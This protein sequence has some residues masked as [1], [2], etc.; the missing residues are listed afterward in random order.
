MRAGSATAGSYPKLQEAFENEKVLSA[1]KMT[2][3]S[4]MLLQPAKLTYSRSVNLRFILNGRVRASEN[5]YPI[6]S[7]AWLG[8]KVRPDEQFKQGR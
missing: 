3:S 4:L 7:K 6:E 2:K 8:A 1:F 5:E